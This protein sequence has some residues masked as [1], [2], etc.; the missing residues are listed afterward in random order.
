MLVS[1]TNLNKFFDGKLPSP[2][3]VSNALTFHSWEI[4]AVEKV[5]EDTVFDVKVLPDK[6]AWA[7][8]HRGIAKDLSVVLDIPLADDP[9]LVPAVLEPVTSKITVSIETDTCTRYSAGL[10]TGV[11][12]G[13]SPEWLVAS[14]NALGQRSINNVVDITNYVMFGL[15]QPLH[16]FDA[17]KLGGNDS[18]SIVVRNA[19][20]GESITTL[21]GELYNL[22]ESDALIVDGGTN[23]PIGIA[24][25]K[26]GKHAEVD[27]GTI[28]IVLESANFKPLA[29]RKTSQRL[30]LRTDA[31]ARYENNVTEELTAFGLRS[32]VTLLE[33]IACGTLIGYVD[34]KS[35]KKPQTPVSVTLS[36][37]NSVLGLKL[38]PEE[39]ISILKRFG[40]VY[41]VD[42]ETV[43]VTPPFERPDLIIAEDVIEEIGRVYGYDHVSAVTIEPIPL[44]EINKNFF[45][46]EKVRDILTSLGFSEVLT[47]S[48]REKD[49]V[50]I[51]N[52]FAEDKGYLRSTLHTNIH[53]TLAK[54]V[55]NVELL[56][57]N[58]VRVFE[59]GT[60]FRTEGEKRS[61]ALGV[62]SKG[63]VN[64]KDFNEARAAFNT[65]LQELGLK[66][67]EKT[68]Y[69]KEGII[70]I[71]FDALLAHLPV[72]TTYTPHVHTD[73]VTYKPF[74]TYPAMSRDIALWVFEGTNA[75]EV[76]EVLNTHAGDLRVRTTFV[77]EF[78]KEGRTSYAFRL[79]F[80]SYEKTLTD[81][82]VNAIME[83][84]YS[85]VRE[86]G[87]EVR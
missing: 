22:E 61:L 71:D 34:T 69:E 63:G 65:L 8:S 4:D 67:V 42:G 47:S 32:A 72:P 27:N 66:T 19:K 50:K 29:V 70:E 17:R 60:V 35:T 79:V 87:W 76:E 18:Y 28:D 21:T 7:L 25:V 84:V 48:F 3:A 14:L 51:A 55:P 30:K 83:T 74:S 9:L 15:G 6:S 31:S 40:Y 77:D 33:E 49:E 75:T 43:M 5:G 46:A 80:Q 26:G 68:E 1:Y 13:P 86:K 12:V 85:A 11:T 73:E 24:G 64:G 58:K 45:Y 20:K 38:Q 52:A 54:N 78:S 57:T 37:I 44:R 41:T 59:I 56:G 53:E 23:T 62:S 36:H 10:I 82:E 39:V 16:A 2:E 81:I